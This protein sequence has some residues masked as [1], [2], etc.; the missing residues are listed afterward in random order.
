MIASHPTL[1]I[2]PYESAGPVRFGMDEK[3]LRNIAGDPFRIRQYPDGESDLVYFNLRVRL[4]VD[5]RVVEVQVHPPRDVRLG[6]VRIFDSP[7]AR[8]DLVK[9]DGWAFKFGNQIVLLNLGIALTGFEDDD[10]TQRSL[11]VFAKG[12]WDNPQLRLEEYVL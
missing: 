7:D 8:K 10:P 3:K 9:Q 5:E 12:R 2:T 11:T 1:L 4:S 6:D